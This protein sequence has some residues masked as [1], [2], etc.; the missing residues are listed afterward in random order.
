MGFLA[1]RAL[2]CTWLDPEI[3]F[4]EQFAKNKLAWSRKMSEQHGKKV[5]VT[6]GSSVSFS[7]IGCRMLEQHGLPTVN[8]GLEAPFGSALLTNWALGELRRGDTL[9]ISIE[10]SRLTC[11]HE[12]FSSACKFANAMG[13]PE[14]AYMPWEHPVVPSWGAAMESNVGWQRCGIV[15]KS[16]RRKKGKPPWPY[17]IGETDASGWQTTA[18]IRPFDELS[19]YY[20][21]HLSADNRKLLR[22]TRE[23][24]DL[25]GVRVA[26][27]LPWAYREPENAAVLQ[28]A[29]C[30]LLQEI[31]EIMPVLKDPRLGAYGGRSHYLD[32][33]YHLS[34]ETAALR[35]DELARQIKA[36]DVWKPGEL[37]A[38]DLVKQ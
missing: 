13:H 5:V 34:P 6:G 21:T 36:W 2:F 38:L 17:T 11:D 24:C 3:G 7:V 27:S 22:W 15:W 30:A 19:P 29:H 26:Y 35:T 33:C 1:F 23:W 16:L 8:M 9:I 4:Y 10:P 32:T 25:H 28:K 37:E 18:R 14:W 20:G 12:L 31:S